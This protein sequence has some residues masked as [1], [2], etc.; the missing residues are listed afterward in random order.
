MLYHG[1]MLLVLVISTVKK[2]YILRFTKKIPKEKERNT[3]EAEFRFEKII[4]KKGDR[5]Y[6]IWNHYISFKSW[7]NMKNIV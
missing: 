3:S 7:I 2:L 6:I 4:K 1:H 5:L